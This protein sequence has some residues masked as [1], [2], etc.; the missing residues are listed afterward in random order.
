MGRKTKY[1]VGNVVN[2]FT[3]L[4]REGI[5]D[6]KVAHEC[7]RVYIVR[8]SSIKKQKK[9]RGCIPKGSNHHAWK[10]YGEISHDLFT[11][12]KHSAAAKDLPFTITIEQLW[13][14]FL[15]QK[16]RCAFTGEELHFNET[17]KGKKNKTASPDRIDSTLGYVDGNIQ[18]VH[19]DVNKLKKNMPN[20]RFLEI[21]LNVAKHMNN[22]KH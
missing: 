13:Q 7:G 20:H 21:C 19:R 10:G 1:E 15:K 11:T 14:L 3:L 4:N 8:T 22:E 12:Y 18:W 16:R 6:W 2:G 17:F 9:C 5:Y